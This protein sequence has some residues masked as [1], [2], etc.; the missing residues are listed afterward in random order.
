M[1]MVTELWKL[2]ISNCQLPI[3]QTQI[4]ISTQI[5]NC[6]RQS[7]MRHR[8]CNES[9]TRGV[10]ENEGNYRCRLKPLNIHHL[11]QESERAVVLAGCNNFGRS[12]LRAKRNCCL[13]AASWLPSC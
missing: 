6:N 12:C 13:A 8:G 4:A 7:T 2:R 9:C 1:G 10:Y 11:S 5:G 3:F